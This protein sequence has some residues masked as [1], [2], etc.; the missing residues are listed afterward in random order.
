MVNISSIWGIVGAAGVSAYQ[1]S[2]GAVRL[3]TKNA[4]ISYAESA[5]RVNS[6]HPGVIDTPMVQA[7]DVTMTEHL[8]S[9]TPMKRLGTPREVAYMAY[10][11]H[12]MSRATSQEPKWWSTADS[13]RFSPNRS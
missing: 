7:Q 12:V 9:V 10:F 6:I 1:A 3:M 2:K 5:I 13:P 4:S 8:A 11:W